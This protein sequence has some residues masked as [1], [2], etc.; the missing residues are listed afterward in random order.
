MTSPVKSATCGEHDAEHCGVILE[1][2]KCQVGEQITSAIGNQHENETRVS[3]DR[4]TERGHERVGGIDHGQE[5]RHC[6]KVTSIASPALR[7]A[8]A[9]AGQ[10]V[11]H[12]LPGL[13]E[14]RLVAILLAIYDLARGAHRFGH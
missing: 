1:V 4:Q 3:G 8:V 6:C 5:L 2:A 12:G 10:K 9:R 11:S 13:E 7:I 14:L